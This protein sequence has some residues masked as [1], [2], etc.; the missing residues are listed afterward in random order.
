MFSVFMAVITVSTVATADKNERTIFGLRFYIVQTNSMSKSES[1]AHL[2]VHF[3]AGDIIIAKIAKDPAALREGE[4]ISFISANSESY[5]ETV[6]HMIRRVE[7]NRDGSTLGYVTYG[8]NT[9]TDDETLVAPEYVLGVYVGKMPAI[10][11]LF[12]YIKT[13]P[14]YIVCILVPML[15]LLLYNG[16]NVVSLFRRYKKEQTAQ[17]DAQRAELAAERQRT[18]EMLREL[19]E[20]KAQLTQKSDTSGEGDK[21]GADT[22]A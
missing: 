18:E 11:Q 22:E 2:D 8:T 4:I 3:N 20:L 12:A 13:T 9:G 16:I 5:G 14:G 6:T 10:G 21:Q 1:N 19:M 17:M 7:T 15:L